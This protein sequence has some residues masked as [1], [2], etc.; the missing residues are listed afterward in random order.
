MKL[1][2]DFDR[3]KSAN[4]R[5]CVHILKSTRSVRLERIN[6]EWTG[7]AWSLDVEWTWLSGSE[8][9]DQHT[10]T[11]VERRSPCDQRY[12]QVRPRLVTTP[13][14]RAT[15][16]GCSWASRVQARRHGVQL[17]AWSSACLLV[18]LC[19]PV[20]DVASRQHLWSAT[21]QL[22][23]VLRHR[24]SFNGRRAF[25]VAGPSV[26]NSPPDSLRDP[27]IGGNSF[28]QSLKTFLFAT[29]WCIQRMHERFYDDALYK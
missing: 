19:Q 11:S 24:L 22:L 4:N 7:S 10:A 17:P 3:T 6:M 2:Y 1:A 5:R 14:Y 28:R 23:V 27:V 13:P 18:E 29:Y 20:A 21:R 15:L 8:S 16:A 12:S 25:Y 9:D 26:W